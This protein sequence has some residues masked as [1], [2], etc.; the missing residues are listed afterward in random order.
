[1]KHHLTK[2][3]NEQFYTDP[4]AAKI[5][6]NYFKQNIGLS[7]FKLIVEPAAGTGSFSD[8]LP[9]NK[10]LA[11]DIDPQ[12]R[13]IKKMDFLKFNSDK[14]NVPR[15][16]VLCIGNPPFGVNSS[17][18]KKFI[19]KC[20]EFSDH[21]AFILPKSFRS[22]SYMKSF[23]MDFH[24]I[25]DKELPTDIFIYPDHLKRKKLQTVFMYFQRKNFDRKKIRQHNPN[26][27]WDYMKN[28][29]SDDVENDS[30]FRVVR[31]A[32]RVGKCVVKGEPNY[33]LDTTPLTDYYIKLTGRNARKN[34]M[35]H[36]CKQIDSHAFVYNN[37]S[38]TLK[39]LN[40]N[41]LTKWLNKFTKK[42]YE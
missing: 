33:Y 3:K 8:L 12:K 36:I 9:K 39:T 2:L 16:K 23:P 17:L 32:G 28:S 21:I 5:I 35:R 1:M 10:L 24:K 30:D 34:A 4:R 37:V 26:K 29:N 19:K 42:F 41:E 11:L 40:R 7:Q 14:I 22:E 31:G 13:G 25:I 18:A 27:Y 38:P 15:N 6:V 20:S